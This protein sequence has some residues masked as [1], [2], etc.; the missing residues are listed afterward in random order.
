[1]H[2]HLK[3]TAKDSAQQQQTWAL[4]SSNMRLTHVSRSVPT[5]VRAYSRLPSPTVY[6]RLLRRGSGTL[7]EWRRARNPFASLDLNFQSTTAKYMGVRR[8]QSL[9]GTWTLDCSNLTSSIFPGSRFL[10]SKLT[11]I[12]RVKLV[13]GPMNA[14]HSGARCSSLGFN[15]PLPFTCTL[16]HKPDARPT[17]KPRESVKVTGTDGVRNPFLHNH[18]ND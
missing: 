7:M 18:G 2:F 12:N 3:W 1:M 8:K 5:E 11:I 13:K 10:S 15:S 4:Q 17:H 9:T 14:W 6:M 16:E